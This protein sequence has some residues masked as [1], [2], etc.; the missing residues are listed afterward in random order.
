[1]TGPL[2]YRLQG[3][4]GVSAALLELPKATAGNNGRA[5]LRAGA[6]PILAEF[7]ATAPRLTGHLVESAGISTKLS[8]RQRGLHRKRDDGRDNL[9]MFVGAGPNPQAIQQEFGN[10]DHPAQPSLTPAWENNKREAIDIIAKTLWDGVRKSAARLARKTA[11][12]RGKA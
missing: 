3:V 11:R 8:R 10:E 2:T 9:E 4:E 1:M 6:Q 5:A 7:Q 12:L